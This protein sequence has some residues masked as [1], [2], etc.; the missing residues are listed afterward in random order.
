[1][2]PVIFIL[3]DAFRFDYI[4]KHQL[5]NLES[6]ISL[7]D[8][9]I[10]K[11]LYPS[12]GYCEIIE[13]FT[14]Q[15]SNEH[16]MF[17]QIT[18]IENWSEIKTPYIFKFL[19]NID[20]KLSGI[21]KVRFVWGGVINKFLRF[22]V[23]D[24]VANIK[25]KVPLSIINKF[26]PTE[27]LYD[28]DSIDFG[29]DKN[30]FVK[31]KEKNINYD[32]DDFVKHNKIQGS[33]NDR[34]ERLFNK[35]QNKSLQDF[36]MIYISA[37]E[38]AHFYGTDGDITKQKLQEFDSNIEKLH[39]TLRENYDDFDLMIVGDHGMLD[40]HDEV[41]IEKV[42]KKV[43]NKYKFKL[44]IDFL[45]FID[46]TVCRLWYS[47]DDIKLKFESYIIDELSEKFELDD[48]VLD[49]LSQFKPKYGDSIFMLKSNNIY[50]PDFFNGI[51]NKGMHGYLNHYKGQQGC[52][53]WNGKK[54]PKLPNEIKLSDVKDLIWKSVNEEG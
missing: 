54:V 43:A 10:I 49:Y 46:S 19:E 16:G 4:H 35:I 6:L 2:K 13:Y 30:V 22:F 33:D 21:R 36:T 25:Y 27:S 28:Y 17:S 32:L 14:G 39:K 37:A 9:Q 52:V 53:I 45:Y 11:E 50:F 3:A 5:S 18:A 8:T 23:P 48:D 15:E 20:L 42:I 24:Y 1:M 29:G 12:T 40:V 51:P 34:F 7:N 47:S 41:N 44:G 26:I 31:M 38:Y